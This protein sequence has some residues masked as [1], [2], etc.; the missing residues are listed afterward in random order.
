MSLL[1]DANKEAAG[2]HL[3][4]IREVDDGQIQPTKTCRAEKTAEKWSRGPGY[5][6]AFAHH[7]LDVRYCEINLLLFNSIRFGF[8]GTCS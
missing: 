8:S 2:Y 5:T 6:V 7:D 3:A 4:A 1:L